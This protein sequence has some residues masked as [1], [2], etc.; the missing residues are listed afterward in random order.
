[1]LFLHRGVAA[2]S[3]TDPWVLAYTARSTVFPKETSPRFDGVFSCHRPASTPDAADTLEKSKQKW[4]YRTAT[5]NRRLGGGAQGSAKAALAGRALA[6]CSFSAPIAPSADKRSSRLSNFRTGSVPQKRC[7]LAVG[8]PRAVRADGVRRGYATR[9]YL[10]NERCQRNSP[11][12]CLRR[13]DS[14]GSLAS[15]RRRHRFDRHC[16]T[17]LKPSFHGKPQTNGRERLGSRYG[18]LHQGWRRKMTFL[19]ARK[20]SIRFGG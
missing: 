1:M 3:P 17:E 4:R 6:R 7:P 12:I 2:R 8:I 13:A 9:P 10:A 14:A 5:T 11:R 18:P 15:L 19:S 20:R 16:I